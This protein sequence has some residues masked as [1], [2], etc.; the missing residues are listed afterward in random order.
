[1]AVS[2]IL[3]NSLEKQKHLQLV[4]RNLVI[5]TGLCLVSLALAFYFFDPFKSGRTYLVVQV[6]MAGLVG[7]FVSIQQRLPS[8]SLEELQ[9]LSHSL[10]SIIL[11]PVNGGIFAIVLHIMFLSDILSGNLFPKYLQANIDAEQ[12]TESVKRWFFSTAP[13]SGPDIAKL[14]FWSF[15]A[16]FCERLVPQIIRKSTKASDGD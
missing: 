1:M 16:G 6:F 10:A 13:A 15:A 9:Q 5:L 14:L 4:T 7:G 2:G 3:M 11:I 8:C 12:V